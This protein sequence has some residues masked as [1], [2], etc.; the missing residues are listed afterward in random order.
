MLL[1]I[2][3]PLKS[4]LRRISEFFFKY[5]SNQKGIFNSIFGNMSYNKKVNFGNMYLVLLHELFQISNFLEVNF[6]ILP[7]VSFL[8]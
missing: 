4:L 7:Y 2:I 8:Q 6:Q 1:S 5:K 3:L